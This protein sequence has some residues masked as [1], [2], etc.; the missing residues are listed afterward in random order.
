MDVACAKQGT[1]LE[2]RG[3][4]L[5]AKAIGG[6]A[7]DVYTSEP[8]TD[9]PF[10]GLENIIM[11]PHL[12]ASTEDAQLTVAVDVARQMIDFLT[13]GAI[14]NAVNVPSLDSETRKELEPLL[15]LVANHAPTVGI[16]NRGLTLGPVGQVLNDERLSALY[17]RPVKVLEVEGRRIVTGCPPKSA[18]CGGE[19]TAC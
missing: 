10:I 6:A 5:K 16:L 7:L 3:K 8:F 12:A 4:T 18:G 1:P 19:A 14:V 13:T 11:T 15:Y 17:G 9:N 2:V